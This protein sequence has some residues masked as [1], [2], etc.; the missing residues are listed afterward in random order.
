MSKPRLL[1]LITEDWYFWSHRR[2]LA[3]S[4]RDAG[5]A[6]PR[7]CDSIPVL[8][9]LTAIQL[10]RSRRRECATY[11]SHV[12]AD[13]KFLSSMPRSWAPRVVYVDA[14]ILEVEHVAGGNHRAPGAGNRCNLR[15]EL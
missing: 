3:E 2:T 9:G 10:S 7:G 14:A 8:R 6:S 5:S 12:I 4:A 13:A 1:F 11:L 15:I